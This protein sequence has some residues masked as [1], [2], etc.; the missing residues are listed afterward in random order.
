MRAD[1]FGCITDR[2]LQRFFESEDNDFVSHRRQTSSV[3]WLGG[4]ATS[5]SVAATVGFTYFEIKQLAGVL[6]YIGRDKAITLCDG[7]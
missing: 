6:D 2:L 5:A 4:G 1:F 7:C 3:S